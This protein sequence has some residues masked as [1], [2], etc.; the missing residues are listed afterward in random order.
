MATRIGLFMEAVD[1]LST[2]PN[3]SFQ[4]KDERHHT[5]QRCEGPCG[6]IPV[7]RSL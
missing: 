4:L 6:L 2:L 7:V 5:S 3:Q 1:C